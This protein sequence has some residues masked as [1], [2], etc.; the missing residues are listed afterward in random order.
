MKTSASVLAIALLAATAACTSSTPAAAPA[1]PGDGT[2][3][4]VGGAADPTPTGPTCD[5]AGRH[6]AE[7]SAEDGE[8]TPAELDALHSAVT[9]ACQEDAWSAELIRC[10]AEAT[11]Q[12]SNDCAANLSEA[13]QNGLMR[14]MMPIIQNHV[15]AAGATGASDDM[16]G[17]TGTRKTEEAAD[18]CEGGE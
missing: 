15:P 16:E 18:P 8:L 2:T 17:G 5:D 10:L 14:R 1:H 3:L 12:G 9:S 4:A 13:Q 7:L 6:A 11:P